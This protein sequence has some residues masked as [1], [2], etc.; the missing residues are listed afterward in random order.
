MWP[1]RYPQ[2]RKAVEGP[3]VRGQWQLDQCYRDGGLHC[4]EWIPG[5]R[6]LLATAHA[7]HV[8]CALNLCDGSSLNPDLLQRPESPLTIAVSM[9][10][11]VRNPGSDMSLFARMC[12]A[13]TT[14][15]RDDCV[16]D[17]ECFLTNAISW[18]S[19]TFHE[20]LSQLRCRSWGWI[21]SRDHLTSMESARM[22]PKVES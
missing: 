14:I 5:F 11:T 21:S 9:T 3:S 10:S 12:S 22:P 8:C 20:T 7:Y 13:L 19:D 4:R 6:A 16:K 18:C 15:Q 1:G 17:P 2:R